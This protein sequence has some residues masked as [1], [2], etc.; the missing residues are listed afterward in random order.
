MNA[1]L[2]RVEWLTT[3]TLQALQRRLR[4]DTFH[5]FHFIGHGGFDEKTDQGVLVLQS[6]A[7]A[8]WLAPADPI[9]SILRDHR[10]LRLVVLNACEGARQ[11]RRDAFGSVA[12]HLV[13]GRIPA[14]VAMQ[15]EITDE[16]ALDFSEEF[17]TVL[18]QGQP[19]DVA[20]AEARKMILGRPNEVEWATPVLY[21]RAQDGLLFDLS[22]PVSEIQ[23]PS[24]KGPTAPVE[25]APPPSHPPPVDA[26][27]VEPL[28][29]STVEPPPPPSKRPR[30]AGPAPTLADSEWE[31]FELKGHTGPVMDVAF[32]PDGR[33]LASCSLDTTIRLWSLKRGELARRWIAHALGARAVAFAPDGKTIASAQKTSVGLTLWNVANG[34]SMRE[35]SGHGDEI[36]AIA[37]AHDGRLVSASDDKTIRIWRTANGRLAKT[38]E[39]HTEWI[40]SVAIS[41]DGTHLTSGTQVIFSAAEI[42]IWDAASGKVLHK[43]QEGLDQVWSLAFSPD[44][45]VLASG[46][47][48]VRAWRVADGKLLF[49]KVGHQGAVNRVVFSPDGTLIA[50]ASDDKT[51]RVWDA[52]T[53]RLLKK[54]RQH[55]EGVNGVAF[56]PDGTLLASASTDRSVRLW[57]VAALLRG[58]DEEAE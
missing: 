9:A 50:S 23:R 13:L 40:R 21:M 47:K 43:M 1:G 36:N 7:G 41:P 12:A 38:F 28:P 39:G 29:V 3:P 15:F 35:V 11:S 37:F 57:K 16:A 34:Q 26:A 48:E 53:G 2:V 14:V 56:S 17:Y 27:L 24:Q 44:G 4:A 58:R 51:I 54:L 52:S 46:S 20:V 22:E 6:A 31:T 5:V 30:Q 45:Q 10:S 19:V 42:R 25:A 8:A 32:S 55:D 33:M 49:K 18:A